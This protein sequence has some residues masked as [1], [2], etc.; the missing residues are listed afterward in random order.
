MDYV[1]APLGFKLKQ[2]IRYLALYGVARTRAKVLAQLHL[3]RRYTRLPPM[4]RDLGARHSV[5]ILGCGNFA[6]ST[7]AYYLCRRCGDVIG[8]CMDRHLERAA[9]L[10]EHY[11]IPRYTTDVSEVIG[12]DLSSVATRRPSRTGRGGYLYRLFRILCG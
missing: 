12:H 6:F 9:S 11:R 3:Q 10:S 4:R 1:R 8:M 2:V 5:A 7:I